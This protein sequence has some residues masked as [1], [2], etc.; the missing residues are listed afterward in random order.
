MRENSFTP[1][2]PKGIFVLVLLFYTIFYGLPTVTE[3][4]S[5]SIIFN[6]NSTSVLLSTMVATS[7][8]LLFTFFLLPISMRQQW[9]TQPILKKEIARLAGLLFVIGMILSWLIP[10]SA[11]LSF[12]NPLLVP[13]LIPLVL[14]IG[15]SEELFFRVL[16][17]YLSQKSGKTFIYPLFQWLF[18]IPHLYQGLT[19]FIFTLLVG[20][21]LANHYAKHGNMHTIALA[22]AAFNFMSFLLLLFA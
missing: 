5:P 1:L 13:L 7:I 6:F 11:H 2:S 4:R 14:I 17:H 9:Q 16:P 22:H 20:F 21:I 10:S 8:P 18:A 12:K 19:G 3:L 15:Y